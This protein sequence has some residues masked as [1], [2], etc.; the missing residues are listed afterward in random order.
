[1]IILIFICLYRRR[2]IGLEMQM[3]T[4][5][6]WVGSDAQELRW[7]FLSV[8]ITANTSTAQKEEDVSQLGFP[9]LKVRQLPLIDYHSLKNSDFTASVSS[10]MW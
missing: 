10:L 5:L 2:G 4:M 3:Q 1:M 6:W 7:V 9:A 8:F